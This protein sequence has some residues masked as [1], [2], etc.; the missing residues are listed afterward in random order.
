MKS[1]ALTHT[2]TSH[3]GNL[4][5]SALIWFKQEYTIDPKP[6]DSTEGVP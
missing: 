6:L 4:P 5:P 1:S 2:R 3:D